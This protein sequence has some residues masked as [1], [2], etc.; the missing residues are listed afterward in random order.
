MTWIVEY[1]QALQAIAGIAVS[2]L[3]LVLIVL[4]GI[5]VRANWRTMRLLEADIRHRTQPLPRMVLRIDQYGAA[6]ELAQLVIIITTENAPLCLSGIYAEI[7][8]DQQQQIYE[9]NI[10]QGKRIVAVDE[11]VQFV[12]RIQ[13]GAPAPSWRVHVDYTDLSQLT[14]F[15]SIFGH[16]GQLETRRTSTRPSAMRLI[17]NKWK[18]VVREMEQT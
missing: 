5:Y 3:T 14:S 1:Q 11:T 18:E 12:E 16:G 13:S 8:N 6:R 4:T 10:F 2:V 9:G 15:V 17:W 7:S